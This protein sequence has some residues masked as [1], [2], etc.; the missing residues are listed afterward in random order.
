MAKCGEGIAKI[1]QIVPCDQ[2]GFRAAFIVDEKV[3]TT[4]VACWLLVD[5]DGDVHIHPA[6]AMG[7]EVTDATLAGNY[8][9]VVSPGE[10][11]VV[12]APHG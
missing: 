9:G 5:H 3:E 10:S 12:E 7:D 1:L 11:V 8:G 2:S 4:P 6:V